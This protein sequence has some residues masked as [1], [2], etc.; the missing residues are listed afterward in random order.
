MTPMITLTTLNA[1]Y[2]HASLGLR[3]LMANLGEHATHTR[4]VEYTIK[5]A[6]D[7][8][9]A[10]LLS[11]APRIIGFG[12]YIWNV[13][14]T[15]A[16]MQAVKAA[17]PQTILIVGGPEVSYEVDQQAITKLADYVITGWGEITL[18]Q[19]LTSLIDGPKPLMKT[20]IGVQ[21][22][23]DDLITP[24]HLYTDHDL[25][26]RNIYVEASR[27]CPFKC[28]FCLSSLD[29]TAWAFDLD[30]FL[31]EM[32]TLYQRGARTFKFVDRTFNLKPDT[33]RRILDFFREKLNDDD[34]IF[35]HFEVIPDHLPELLKE[36]IA[37]FP[38]GSLQFEIGIQ[39][40]NTTVQKHI[41]RKT[42]LTKAEANVRWLREHSH[43]HLHVDLIAGLP[44]ETM[45]SF[46]EGF[47]RLYQWDAHEIQIGILKR[48][49]G[50]PIIRHTEAFGMVYSEAPPYEIISNH[51]VS[52]AELDAFKHFAKYWDAIANSGRFNQTLPLIMAG[53]S[54]YAR[55]ADL[56]HYLNTIWQ[57]S[58]SIV[59]EKLFT[60]VANWLMSRS[61]ESNHDDIR[62]AVTADYL[63]SGAQGKLPWMTRGLTIQT[64]QKTDGSLLARQA[65]HQTMTSSAN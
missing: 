44:S 7:E 54:P 50:T 46:A 47:D 19:L 24:Y 38:A 55:F 12:V 36:A 22:K 21:A 52:Q 61:D 18:P 33:G 35:A 23:L 5:S 2:S 26:H 56:S 29:K 57:R 53:A 11:D 43:A 41:S 25:A 31:R 3:Y 9:V 48:L 4:M 6:T 64:K 62:H 51:D 34:P 37:A 17:A 15:L 28:E 14:E 40:L 65:R 42:D 20:H 59:L 13:N 16:L 45:A 32:E 1:R 39:T 49:R 10:D 27:G 8:M 60:E 58:H 30:H 63:A